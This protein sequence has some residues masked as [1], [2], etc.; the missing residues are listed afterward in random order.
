MDS[1]TEIRGIVVFGHVQ[2]VGFRDFT[3]RLAIGLGLRGEV[4][5][6][7]DGAVEMVVAGLSERLR[8]FEARLLEG[9]GRPESVQGRKEFLFMEPGM[10]IGPTR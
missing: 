7:S 1:P 6:R 3:R 2:G 4:W 10:R 8:E 9:P 5:N